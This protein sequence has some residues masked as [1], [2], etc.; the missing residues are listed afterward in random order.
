MTYTIL[1]TCKHTVTDSEPRCTGQKHYCR[2]CCDFKIAVRLV[3]V[4]SISCFNCRFARSYG[5]SE[6]E[7]VR[8]ASSHLSRYPDHSI[9]LRSDRVLVETLDG[10]NVGSRLIAVL[11][12]A[13]AGH[14]T[15]LKNLALGTRQLELGE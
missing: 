14:Q 9:A 6:V 13:N 5:S 2:L 7:A 4:K 1:L 11:R 8:A 15:S 3:N 10:L 12:Q